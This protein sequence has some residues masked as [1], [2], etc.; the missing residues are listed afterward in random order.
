MKINKI[1]SKMKNKQRSITLE[2]LMRNKTCIF[3]ML[4]LIIIWS[5]C[6]A[7]VTT[8]TKIDLK[9]FYF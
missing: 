9:K 5:E 1:I 7:D 8:F 3:N 6:E 2:G 4:I